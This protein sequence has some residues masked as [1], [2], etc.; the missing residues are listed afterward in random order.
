MQKLKTQISFTKNQN[1]ISLWEM[2]KP[3]TQISVLTNQ[4]PISLWEMKPH[5][6]LPSPSR[7]PPAVELVD[8]RLQVLWPLVADGL[9]VHILHFVLPRAVVDLLQH[10]VNSTESFKFVI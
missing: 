1:P 6:L 9:L 8:H 5:L 2:E 10:P 4:N 3:K 7:E